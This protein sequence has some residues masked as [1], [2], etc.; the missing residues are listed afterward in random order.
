NRLSA[1]EKYREAMF[2]SC[3]T[4][5]LTDSRYITKHTIWIENRKG[6]RFIKYFC[7]MNNKDRKKDAFVCIKN[8]IN[9]VKV[10]Y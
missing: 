5:A 4:T 8:R 3:A 9:M 2:I 6:M 7:V 10:Y 1:L